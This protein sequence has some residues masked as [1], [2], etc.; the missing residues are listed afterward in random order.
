[1]FEIEWKYKEKIGIIEVPSIGEG[2]VYKTDDGQ[3]AKVKGDKHAGKSKVKKTNIVDVEKLNS[4][5]EF[6]EKYANDKERLEQGYAKLK[7]NG[8]P[9]DKSSTGHFVRWL[10]NDIISETQDVMIE[11]GIEIKD[12]GGPISKVAQRWYFNKIEEL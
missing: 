9:Y 10:V 1:M 4:I 7:E 8:F 11:S 12:V 6:V 5:T 2:V 3:R